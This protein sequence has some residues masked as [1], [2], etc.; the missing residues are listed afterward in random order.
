M[1]TFSKYLVAAASVSFAFLFI[2][3][4]KFC[5]SIR[6][7][8][9]ENSS[10]RTF[11]DAKAVNGVDCS[12]AENL[13]DPKVRNLCRQ[14]ADTWKGQVSAGQQVLCGKSTL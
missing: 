13:A 9:G 8:E 12:K 14:N 6:V 7:A 11:I 4:P 5:Q 2:T 3:P 10:Y 1:K